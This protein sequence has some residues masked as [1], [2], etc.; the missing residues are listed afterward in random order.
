MKL[1]TRLALLFAGLS[2][3]IFHGFNAYVYFAE[4]NA[5]SPQPAELS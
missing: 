2:I 3:A 1:S 5:R 4:R